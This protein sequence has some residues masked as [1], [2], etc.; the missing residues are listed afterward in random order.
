MAPPQSNFNPPLAVLIVVG[1]LMLGIGA[2]MAG[3]E[4][5]PQ[6]S[7]FSEPVPTEESIAGPFLMGI[8]AIMLIM[9]WAAGAICYQIV[10]Q[11]APEG[12]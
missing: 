11:R 12:T 5:E 10:Q 9:A 3:Q 7:V 1:V 2:I 6:P 4:P 8:G